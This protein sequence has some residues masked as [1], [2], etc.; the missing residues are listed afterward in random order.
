MCPLGMG[1]VVGV[2][3]GMPMPNKSVG[4]DMM[5]PWLVTWRNKGKSYI[6]GNCFRFEEA[7]KAGP[8][9]GPCER[10]PHEVILGLTQEI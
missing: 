3:S 5:A 10:E 4:P 9:L 7:K 6:W 2:F 8:H 1:R